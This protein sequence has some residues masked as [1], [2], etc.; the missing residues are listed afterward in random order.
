[1]QSKFEWS[2]TYFEVLRKWKQFSFYCCGQS[3]FICS[4]VKWSSKAARLRRAGC[5]MEKRRRLRIMYVCWREWWAVSKNT[6]VYSLAWSKPLASHYI[7]WSF[8]A[9]LRVWNL[10]FRAQPFILS[11]VILSSD[12]LKDLRCDLFCLFGTPGN[13]EDPGEEILILA[14][15]FKI[16]FC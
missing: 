3:N 13:F 6:L 9:A 10:F 8:K 4:H 11:H 2:A 1:V 12:L 15:L 14:I 7:F 5:F 16:I